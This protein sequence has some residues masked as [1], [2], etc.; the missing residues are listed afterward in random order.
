[1]LNIPAAL[2]TKYSILLSKKSV[3]VS[4]HN[5]Y[6]K[7]LRYY[8]DFCH[9][10]CYGYAERESLEHFMVKLH[11]K[12][13]SPAMQE[14]AAQAVSLYYEMLRSA[15]HLP[16]NHAG[17]GAAPLPVRGEGNVKPEDCSDSL[18]SPTPLF[19]KEEA[20]KSGALSGKEWGKVYSDLFAEIKVR[21]YSPKTLRSYSTWVR[22]FQAFTKSKKP[23]DLNPSDVKDFIRF[24]AVQCRVSASSQNQAFHALLFLY[25]HVLKTDFGDQSDN[26]RAR[27]TRYI[28]VV[29]SRAEV[30]SVIGNL[31][32]PYDLVVRLLYGCGLRLFECM[33]LRLHNFNLDA[34][35]LTVHDGKG[36]KDRTVPLPRS[37]I[38]QIKNHIAY[39]TELHQKDLDAGYA[40]AFVDGLLEK[41][42]KNIGKELIWQWFFPAKTLTL[43]PDEG[44][45]R[46]YH[47]HETHVNKAIR[48]AVRKAKILKRVSSHT[49]RHSFAT[50]LLQANYDIRTIQEMLG[51]RDVRTTMIYTHTIKSQTVK[52]VKSP[53]DF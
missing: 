5:N 52:E 39:V 8:L 16:A 24:L 22:K 18:T 1:M 35:I 31:N 9:N 6:K 48:R 7:W 33:K 26:V 50:H 28:P 38:P 32:Y 43:V 13:Q 44:K 36:K 47:L 12:H 14:E 51:H 41:K 21:H 15:P 11:E 40:G 10:H 45:Y 20:T 17:A 53:L 37:I 19:S 46:R 3:P 30:D 2:F 34:G 25:R 42:Y 27:R 23:S 29:L 49:F 4:L